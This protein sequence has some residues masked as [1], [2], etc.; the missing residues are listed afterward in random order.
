MKYPHTQ[1]KMKQKRNAMEHHWLRFGFAGETTAGF[2]DEVVDGVMVTASLCIDDVFSF[3]F[4]FFA[5]CNN[6][7]GLVVSPEQR[8]P[9]FS[10]YS[11]ELTCPHC[12]LA[13]THFVKA[14][15]SVFQMFQPSPASNSPVGST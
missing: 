15:P 9:F 13:A 4:S 14:L 11:R 5:Q 7:S 1:K 10:Q 12:S 8:Y 6:C 2:N 3:L